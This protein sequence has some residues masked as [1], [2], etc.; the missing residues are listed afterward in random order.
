MMNH[1][2]IKSSEIHVRSENVMRKWNHA[3]QKDVQHFLEDK[4]LPYP[5]FQL[6]RSQNQSILS[7]FPFWAYKR[8]AHCR[9][10]WMILHEDSPVIFV[11]TRDQTRGY[12]ARIPFDNGVIQK[13]GSVCCEAY[14]D[15]QD[16]SVYVVD[17]LYWNHNAIYRTMPFHERW[18][19]LNKVVYEICFAQKCN[20][21]NLLVPKFTS[22]AEMSQEIMDPA[23][24]IEFQ[25]DT[26]D[27]RRFLY[28]HRE[29]SHAQ[30]R[31][32]VMRDVSQVQKAG[33]GAAKVA[34][35]N[36]QNSE[37]MNRTRLSK[38]PSKGYDFVEDNVDETPAIAQVIA[39]VQVKKEEIPKKE[40]SQ[41][42]AKP[43]SGGRTLPPH[44]FDSPTP[45]K[46]VVN[47]LPPRKTEKSSVDKSLAT[48]ICKKDPVSKLPDCYRLYDSHGNDIGLAALRLF[49]ITQKVRTATE[50]AESCKVSICW[51]EPFGKF[52]IKDVL[53]E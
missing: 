29:A 16:R 45:V 24:A 49:A 4:E 48:A 32:I 1:R 17:L 30:A 25:P 13:Y 23:V 52:E 51:H 7:K 12:T 53:V 41:T 2:S 35:R 6:L 11:E 43:V 42:V 47:A 5:S 26:P 50:K 21:L 40:V 37:R 33:Y 18:P 46:K 9:P 27:K 14:I 39:P 44:Y 34:L 28:I 8:P 22:L 38:E 36:N 15:H 31:D 10:C 20:D 3:F 19:L